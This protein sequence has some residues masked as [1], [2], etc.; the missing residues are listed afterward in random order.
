MALVD[1]LWLAAITGIQ[2]PSQRIIVQ[3]LDD[4]LKRQDRA[5]RRLAEKMASVE[6]IQEELDTVTTDLANRWEEIEAVNADLRAAVLAGET[7]RAQQLAE[8]AEAY[9]AV[10]S[11][12]VTKLREIGA[13]VDNPVPDP[14][15]LPDP[16]PTPPGPDTGDAPT[17]DA[18]APDAGGGGDATAP[19]PDEPAPDVPAPDDTA[20]PPTDQT[21]PGAGDAPDTGT[22]DPGTG[23]AGGRGR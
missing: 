14:A 11:A 18:P 9:S 1:D 20:T 4:R 13:D 7:A 16:E 17:T 10:V 21:D 22:V 3:M 5:I 19:V 23:T 6:E 8:Q 15:P 2:D 12:G